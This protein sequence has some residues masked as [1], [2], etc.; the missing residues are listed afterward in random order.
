MQAKFD[1]GVLRITLAKT[2]R[3]KKKEIKVQVK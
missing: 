1:K 3:A 2:V